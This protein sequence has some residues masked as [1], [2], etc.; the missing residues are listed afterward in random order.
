MPEGQLQEL[1][2]TQNVKLPPQPHFKRLADVSKQG[3][4]F[5]KYVKQFLYYSSYLNIETQ[6]R[7]KT[8]LLIVGGDVFQDIW[9]RAIRV[10]PEGLTENSPEGEKKLKE[11][12][13]LVLT[14]S[15]HL[16]PSQSKYFNRY[17][18]STLRQRPGETVGDF[19]LRLRIQAA[20]CS[21]GATTDERILES[22]YVGIS[23][24]H[25]RQKAFEEDFDLHKFLEYSASY[26]TATSNTSGMSRVN[27][28][29]NSAHQ[30]G[31]NTNKCGNCGRFRGEEHQC[32]ARGKECS[33]CH[34]TGHF[35]IVC[36]KKEA[37]G[38]KS[39]NPKPSKPQQ[40][41]KK[42]GKGKSSANSVSTDSS[43]ES[44][45]PSTSQ[46]APAQAL[47]AFASHSI[48]LSSSSM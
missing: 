18:F 38:N 24:V 5:D 32:P 47:S 1:N 19:H 17:N 23:N 44:A 14:L 28:S 30:Q 20:Y 15:K 46:E 6:E 42:G 31:K 10:Y 21:F 7:K 25:I 11:F 35:A 41:W 40:K 36:R 43:V 29:A 8:A 12:D 3:I 2:L 26:E 48:G 37:A 39:P 13:T 45:T 4:A 27:K 34:L 22:L 9:E 16:K 33:F